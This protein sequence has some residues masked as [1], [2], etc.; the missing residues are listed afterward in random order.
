MSERLLAHL[1]H[2]EVITPKPE[3]SLAFYRDLLGLE[4]TAEEGDSVYLR[5][6]GEHYAH[7]LQLTEGPQPAVAHTGWRTEGPEELE[8]LAERLDELGAG[9]G[10]VDDQF[11]HGRAFRY[12]GPGGHLQELFWEVD[13]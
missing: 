12:R 4:V 5:G 2:V 8:T 7:S 1:A 3:E 9:E 11:G 10:W 6:W 13:R